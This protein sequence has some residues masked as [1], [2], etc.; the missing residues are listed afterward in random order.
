MQ[1]DNADLLTLNDAELRRE[2]LARSAASTTALSV[3]DTKL[4]PAALDITIR[5]YLRWFRS[6]T[7]APRTELY[8]TA[9]Q[10][11]SIKR[12]GLQERVVGYHLPWQKQVDN[13]GRLISTPQAR[14]MAAATSFWRSPLTLEFQSRT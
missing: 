10:E 4:P 3:I 12:L 13:L 6:L 14:P 7:G 2:I 9:E 5:S 1:V 11:A 8:T